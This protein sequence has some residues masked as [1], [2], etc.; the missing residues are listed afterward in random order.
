MERFY[1]KRGITVAFNYCL[2]VLKA[3]TLVSTKIL[4]FL[5][6]VFTKIAIHFC[7]SVAIC[8]AIPDPFFPV[9]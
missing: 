4:W 3:L 2:A 9:V 7:T 8:Y 1:V 5:H 6:N